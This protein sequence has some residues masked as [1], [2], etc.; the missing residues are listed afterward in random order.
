MNM[1]VAKNCGKDTT[2]TTPLWKRHDNYH[3]TVEK[4]RQLPHHCGKDVE[5]TTAPWER[6]GNYH[7]TVKR[8]N[9]RE[10]N[11]MKASNHKSDSSCTVSTLAVN[12]S[13]R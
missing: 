13:A 6:R 7:N 12:I 9:N 5:I 11:H 4:T 2:I 1:P 10:G 3:T 8:P